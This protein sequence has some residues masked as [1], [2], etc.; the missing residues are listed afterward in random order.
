MEPQVFTQVWFDQLGNCP[1]FS[2][3]AHEELSKL[4]GLVRPRDVS[5]GE[6]FILQDTEGDSFFII[7]EGKTE[8]F[9]EDDRGD[10]SSLETVG[11]GGCL[12]EM[13][14][15]SDGRRSAS[16]RALEDTKLLEIDYSALDEVFDTSP[17]VARRFLAIVS[18]RL[19]HTNLRFQ[20][21]SQKSRLI[22]N[23]LKN[24]HADSKGCIY[25]QQGNER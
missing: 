25:G 16:V 2:G 12:G 13:G 6:I 22:E 17:L 3:L 20:E 23:S 9:R 24:I 21:L 10:K 4:F 8:V 19:R 1:L 5:A 18:E 7:L 14:Y 15:F 11:A